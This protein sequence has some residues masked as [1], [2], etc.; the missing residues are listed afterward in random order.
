MKGGLLLNV[1]VGE[2]TAIFELLAG[3]DET[4]LVWGDTLLVLN[5]RLDVI[6]GVRR[7]DLEG[8]RLA[9]ESLNK[10][11]H[12][13]KD[14]VTSATSFP[15]HRTTGTRTLWC[16]CEVWKVVVGEREAVA[17]GRRLIKLCAGADS[18]A[19]EGA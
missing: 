3:E 17:S 15:S 16:V 1:V 6:D 14:T 5:L 7:L 10:D 9:R 2:G 18:G 8:D 19:T 11:L 4:L 12:A 13:T